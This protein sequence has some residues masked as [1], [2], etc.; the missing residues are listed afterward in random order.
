[1]S[2]LDR[3]LRRS[4]AGLDPNALAPFERALLADV[5]S[6]SA[7]NIGFISLK[8]QC[9]EILSFMGGRVIGGVHNWFRRNQVGN[10]VFLEQDRKIGSRF[11]MPSAKPEEYRFTIHRGTM[12]LGRLSIISRQTIDKLEI[13]LNETSSSYPEAESIR[14]SEP[15]VEDESALWKTRMESV[16]PELRKIAEAVVEFVSKQGLSENA[17][18]PVP[19]LPDSLLVCGIRVKGSYEDLLR[20]CNG[21]RVNSLIVLGVATDERRLF[22]ERGQRF[23]DLGDDDDGT[24]YALPIEGEE[25]SDSVIGFRSGSNEPECTGK[26]VIAHCRGALK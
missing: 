20:L 25:A 14:L 6:K 17:V 2:W 1:M 15:S 19:R 11:G 3:M 26:T 12:L 9:R 7:S 4:V 10:L 16:D 23:L 22:Q 24:M 21:I 18:L 13:K 5:V 8:S